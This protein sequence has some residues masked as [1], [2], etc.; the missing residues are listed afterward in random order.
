MICLNT[1]CLNT[2]CLNTICLNTVCLGMMDQP[3][4]DGGTTG[5]LSEGPTGGADSDP[6][7]SDREASDERCRT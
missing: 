2:I 4:L 3:Q 5:L 7:M 1:I 6:T